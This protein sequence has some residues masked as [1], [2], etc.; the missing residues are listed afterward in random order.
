MR[1]RQVVA[2]L[3]LLGVMAF[4]SSGVLA[5]DATPPASDTLTANSFA[6]PFAPSADLC[7]TAPMSTDDAAALLAT[8]TA[9][10]E[11]PITDHNIIALPG[12]TPADEATTAGVLGTLTQMWACNNAQNSAAILSLFSP[13]GLQMTAGVTEDS[14]WSYE[15][16][17]AAVAAKLTPEDPR[18]EADY[19]SIDAVVSVLLQEDGT[20]G[21]LV[22]NSDPL[23]N[24]GDQVLDYFSFVNNGGT[25]QISRVALDPF[26]L[27]PDYGFDGEA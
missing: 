15:E 9:L 11:W 24:D 10:V 21:V 17:R 3:A 12:G 1:I 16:I 23:I 25:W 19:A 8:P 5:Q 18:A 4:S 13:E 26:D 14:T 7:T 22:L 6:A 20:V 2:G 27:A